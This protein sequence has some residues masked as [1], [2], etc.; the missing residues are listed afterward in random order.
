[1]RI[2]NEKGYFES[3]SLSRNKNKTRQDQTSS[4][5]AVMQSQSNTKS[6]VTR[7]DITKKKETSPNK[8][9]CGF[10]PDDPNGDF[11]PRKKPSTN[12]HKTEI[13]PN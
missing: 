2:A 6:A 10:N 12:N 5:A 9:T 1:M 4:K 7:S 13:D 3:L 8:N 11:Q